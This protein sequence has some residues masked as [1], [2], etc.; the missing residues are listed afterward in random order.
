MSYIRGALPFLIY[1]ASI[2]D[3]IIPDGANSTFELSQEVPGGYEQNVQV[4]RQELKHDQVVADT[5]TISFDASLKRI[6]C[7]N[8]NVATA[9]AVFDKDNLIKITG[10]ANGA[11]NGQFPVESVYYDGTQIHIT[12]PS[13]IILANESAGS[14]ITV[15]RLYVGPWEILLPEVDYTIGGLDDQYN[16]LIS[17]AKV[18]AEED[19]IYVLHR[20]EATYNFVPSQGSVGPDQL[21]QNLRNFTVDLFQGD[22]VVDTFNLSQSAVSGRTL[23]VSI[24]G[25]TKYATDADLTFSGD[26][27]L[28]PDGES[29]TFATPPSNGATIYVRHLGFTTVSRRQALSAS[30]IGSLAPSSVTTNTIANGAV[31]AAKLATNS[32]GNSNII[33]NAVDGQK[34]LLQFGQFLRSL[35]SGA[36]AKDLVGLSGD[37][38]LVVKSPTSTLSLNLNNATSVDV[39]PSGLVDSGN[40]GQMDLGSSS[41][42]FRNLNLSGAATVNS[43][44]AN[45]ATVTGNI[46]VDG[47]VD[48]VDV[49]ALQ[50]QVNNLATLIANNT[51]TGSIKMWAKDSATPPSGWLLCDGSL[52]S[53]LTYASL[54][55]EIGY[56]FGGGG[57]TFAVPDMRGRFPLGKAASGTGSDWGANG[58]GGSLDHTHATPSHTHGLANHVHTVPGH[59]H[60]YSLGNGSSLAISLSGDHTTDISHDHASFLTPATEGTHEHDLTSNAIVVASESGHTHNISTGNALG[61]HSH[62]SW[63]YGSQPGGPVPAPGVPGSNADMLAVNVYISDPGHRHQINARDGSPNTFNSSFFPTWTTASSSQNRDRYTSS[64]TTG[65]TAA[66]VALPW[67]TDVT[68]LQHAHTGN[69]TSNSGHTHGISGKI[70]INSSSAHRHTIDVPAFTST[71]SSTGVHTHNSSAFSG[72]IG[73]SEAF[74]GVDGNSNF[75]T[76]VPSPNV[77]DAGGAGTTS[78][79]NPAYQTINFIIKT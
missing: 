70:T 45:S 57:S 28:A 33:N 32:V 11:N 16:R 24:D 56:A 43:I 64:E 15:E 50:S 5:S 52:Y 31:A 36:I 4:I 8:A 60:A 19:F 79:A 71:S 12:V 78:G 9:L 22:G 7:S 68:N 55:A 30:Q 18:P 44:N 49:S 41:K 62:R 74:G 61:T 73:R 37:G 6:S 2:R 67:T 72:Y 38:N 59:G 1:N 27:T 40:T 17:F 10:A 48:G 3:D 21:Q 66:G 20:G 46:A 54:F 75:N 34:I 77:S 42:K 14:S 26:F 51:P 13:N 39:S 23:E 63:P 53:T 25:V 58:R 35:D 65:I 47:T 29:I 76:Q 69:T